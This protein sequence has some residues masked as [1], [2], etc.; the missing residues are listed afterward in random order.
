VGGQLWAMVLR[1]AQ[2]TEAQYRQL[3]QMRPNASLQVA[4]NFPG[5]YVGH[6]NPEGF[7]WKHL[8]VNG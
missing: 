2:L 1:N 5:C 8:L 4:H 7:A 6:W 3:H